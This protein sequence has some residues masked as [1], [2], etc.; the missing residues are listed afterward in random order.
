MDTTQ[1]IKETIS[2]LNPIT[3]KSNEIIAKAV[4]KASA[5][6]AVPIPLLDIAAII[7]V[8]VSMVEKLANLHGVAVE[9]RSKLLISSTVSAIISKLIS[10][11]VISL[12]QES[13]LDKVLGE[14]LVKASI[15]GFVTTITGEVYN[16]HFNRG[17]DLEDITPSTYFDYFQEQLQSDR[18]SV[19]KIT[20]NIIDNALDKFGLN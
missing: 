3:K 6:A 14:S 17:G 13:S 10:E 18:M 15:S 8:Q 2:E 1:E 19:E 5:I 20:S 11:A 7:Y 12:T 16:A 9:N 4:G